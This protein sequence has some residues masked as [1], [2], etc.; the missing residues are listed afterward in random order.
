[1]FK[2]PLTNTEAARRLRILLTFIVTESPVIGISKHEMIR[3]PSLIDRYFYGRLTPEVRPA[4]NESVKSASV[5]TAGKQVSLPVR[6]VVHIVAPNFDG[7]QWSLELALQAWSAGTKNRY[8]VRVLS[9]NAGRIDAKHLEN[10]II[11]KRRKADDDNVLTFRSMVHTSFTVLE[12][13]LEYLKQLMYSRHRVAI[14]IESNTGLPQEEASRILKRQFAGGL[15]DQREVDSLD[16]VG[17]DFIFPLRVSEI[18]KS[19]LNNAAASAPGDSYSGSPDRLPIPP[20]ESGTPVDLPRS[21]TPTGSAAMDEMALT[22]ILTTI[23]RRNYQAIGIIASNP[24]DTVFLARRVRRFCPNLRIFA[25]HSDLLFARPQNLG[26][27]RGMLVASTY[28]LYPANQRII[29]SSGARPHV[30]FSN[31]GAQRLYNAVVAHLW[32]M[33]A[34]QHVSGP[35]LLEF[36]RPYNIA[37]RDFDPPIWISAVGERGV[38]PVTFSHVSNDTSYLY[39][40]TDNPERRRF[41]PPKRD[42]KLER[43]R[44]NAMRTSVHLLYLLY[45]LILYALCFALTGLTLLYAQWATDTDKNKPLG[46][47][48]YLGFGHL[49]RFLNCESRLAEPKKV[50]LPIGESLQCPA[51]FVAGQGDHPESG[52]RTSSD[53]GQPSD[54]TLATSNEGHQKIAE[55]IAVSPAPSKVRRI[56]HYLGGLASADKTRSG[57]SGGS[58][59]E[60]YNP[61]QRYLDGKAP[62]RPRLG[63]G[64]YL[65]LA[66]LLLFGLASYTFSLMLVGQRPY[67]LDMP[68]FPLFVYHL[69]HVAW[70]LTFASTVMSLPLDFTEVWLGKLNESKPPYQSIINYMIFIPTVIVGFWITLAIS[71]GHEAPADWRLNFERTTK[72]SKRRITAFPRAVFDYVVRHFRLLPIGA[73]PYVPTILFFL[74]SCMPISRSI[75]KACLNRE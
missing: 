33:G 51:S 18:R 27:L 30:L 60:P 42:S 52:A 64:I 72:L 32:E 55:Q 68:V 62:C 3:S 17:E 26:D 67:K 28:S 13:M 36:A 43:R 56:A 8:H 35:Q 15:H 75:G 23:S 25:T 7:A 34:T 48:G 53:R 11:D 20:D 57:E 37:L 59:R 5:P 6:R 38:F 1:V 16:E 49:L 50:E 14:L 61:Q 4:E 22:Q 74:P 21:F 71:A 39:D 73:A 24:F 46:E 31:Q 2:S 66:N 19:Y 69:T 54:A 10:S 65:S 40:P 70:A 12:R 58:R 63:A 9:N 41:Q 47:I 29:T 44:Y 45:C